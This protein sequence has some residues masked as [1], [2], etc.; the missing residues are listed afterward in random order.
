MPRP[1][2]LIWTAA[3]ALLTFLAAGTGFANYDAAY[4]LLW[5]SELAAG[6]VPDLEV[7]VAP[8][9]HPLA[10]AAG[11]VL[12]PLGDGAETV[13]VVVA[14]VSLGALGAVTYRLGAHWFGAAAG[15]VAAVIVLTRQPVLS[16]GA[17]AYVDIPYLVLVLAALLVE[18]RRP[19]AGIRVLVLLVL[20]GLLR[21]EAWL[22][23]G[24]Y[25]V[26]LL[27]PGGARDEPAP[28]AGARAR[29]GWIVLA[30]SAPVLWALCDLALTGDPL[31]SLTGTRSNAE[32]LERVTGLQNV[33]LTAP[34][35]V[36][37][38]LREP[39][40][41]AAAGGGLLALALLPARAR[42]GTAAGALAFAA[43]CV[44]AAAGLPILGR[45]L[46]L[47]AVLLAIFAGAGVAGWR[48][49]P[50]G[51]P[52][53]RRWQGF[54]VLCV[55]ALAAFAPAQVER[56]DDLHG[57]LVLQR[58]IRDDLRDIARSVPCRP[59]R[60]PNHRPVPLLALWTGAPVRSVVPVLEGE[61]SRLLP[62]T[63]RVARN[64]ILDPKDPVPAPTRFAA[65]AGTVVERN[66]SWVLTAQCPGGRP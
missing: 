12:S 4:A 32:V 62:A 18:A 44:L 65:A 6:R 35:R 60:V 51:H 8:T 28:A 58:A 42:L 49:L 3:G 1:G 47:V 14:F 11:A 2:T 25:V 22:F 41:L 30:G 57:S 7:P 64:F 66:A 36:G 15:A 19:R 10:I 52:W 59:I 29:V 27:W 38:I 23:S 56:V 46:L 50:P 16:F 43:F 54:A 34:R 45:Y 33:P 5:G 24:A 20:A 48:R 55:L 61:G 37:E 21:P 13:L 26:W 17:R 31:H 53:R 40:L 9:P 39:V 63:A